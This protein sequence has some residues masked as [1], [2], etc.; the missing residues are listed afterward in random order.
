MLFLA[1]VQCGTKVIKAFCIHRH[2]SIVGL[3]VVTSA[4]NHFLETKL[5]ERIA[6]IGK[7]LLLLATFLTKVV[8]VPGVGALRF[9][10]VLAAVPGRGKDSGREIG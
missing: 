6:S 8:K 9:A 2:S 7:R 10:L 4:L 3:V 1:V 5:R